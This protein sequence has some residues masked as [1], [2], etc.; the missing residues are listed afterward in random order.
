MIV[1]DYVEQAAALAEIAH[2]GQFDKCGAPYFEHPTAVAEMLPED[3]HEGRA[4]AYLHDILEDTEITSQ[5]L[6]WMGIPVSVID[7]VEILT[8]K[9]F[10]PNETYWLRIRLNPLALRVKAADIAH[11][12][13]PK[14]LAKLDS[15]TASRLIRK[16]TRARDF[17]GLNDNESD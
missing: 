15:M 11:N 13:D 7:A 14:R 12:L 10:E 6:Y 4:A 17:L 8:H 16:Y 1:P 9:P 5:I 2:R 3:D